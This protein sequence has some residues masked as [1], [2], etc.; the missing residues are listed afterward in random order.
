[1]KIRI[2]IG[3]S[4]IGTLTIALVSAISSQTEQD[5]SKDR[6]VIEESKLSRISAIE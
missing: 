6:I 1:M 4:L 5:I 2:M 3:L